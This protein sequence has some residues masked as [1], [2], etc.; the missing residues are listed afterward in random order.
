VW[1]GAPCGVTLPLQDIGDIMCVQALD[2]KEA[3]K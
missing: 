2:G 1:H 3:A